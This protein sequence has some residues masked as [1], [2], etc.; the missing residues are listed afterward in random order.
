MNALHRD[1]LAFDRQLG[2]LR[3]GQECPNLPLRGLFIAVY[4]MWPQYAEGV[5]V[6]AADYCFYLLFRHRTFIMSGE[7]SLEDLAE[8]VHALPKA[9]LH[10]H[11]EGSVEPE[12]IQELDPSLP[13]DEIRANFQYSDFGG[14]LRAY[15]WVTRQLS[16]PEAYALAT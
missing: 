15:V 3:L 11:L 1:S 10:V 2:L 8:F 16:S 5:S 9:E 7:P 6:I 12:T 13:L 4:R 14:F